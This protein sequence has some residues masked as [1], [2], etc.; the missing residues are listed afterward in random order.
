MRSRPPPVYEFLVY[1]LADP[2]DSLIHYVGRSSHGLQRPRAHSPRYNVSIG[3]RAWLEELG[4]AGLSY[5]IV[6]LER[7]ATFGALC[8]AEARWI[9]L[10]RGAGWPLLNVRRSA[11]GGVP[12]PD[13]LRR[14]G[15]SIF[16]VLRGGA[17]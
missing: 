8:E 14:Y 1:G 10:G 11:M 15:P 9:D 7:C 13:R 3:R 6:V 5:R 16:D 12:R 2:R 4:R 17:A